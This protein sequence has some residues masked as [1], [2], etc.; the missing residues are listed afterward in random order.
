[1]IGQ[2]IAPELAMVPVRTLLQWLGTDDRPVADEPVSEAAVEPVDRPVDTVVSE[3]EACSTAAPVAEPE[4]GWALS[5]NWT[6]PQRRGELRKPNFSVSADLADSTASPDNWEFGTGRPLPEP[7]RVAGD[8]AI[9]DEPAVAAEAEYEP[10]PVFEPVAELEAPLEPVSPPRPAAAVAASLGLPPPLV[11]PVGPTGF[12]A[13][14]VDA[15]LVPVGRSLF[16]ERRLPNG[17]DEAVLSEY[18]AESRPAP[19]RVKPGPTARPAR[20]PAPRVELP[21]RSVGRR[22]PLLA[23]PALLG[24]CVIVY[25]VERPAAPLPV[26]MGMIRGAP[27]TV[28]S[29]VAGVLE[30]RLAAPGAKLM[31][32][33]G[34][35]SVLPEAD[36]AQA[37]LVAQQFDAARKHA[38]E[39]R[40][41]VDNFSRAAKLARTPATRLAVANLLEQA[42]ADNVAAMDELDRLE[43][44]ALA[45]TQRPAPMVVTAERPAIVGQFLIGDGREVG[46]GAAVVEIADCG[47]LDVVLDAKQAAKIGFKG[48]QAVRIG[49][50]GNTAGVALHLPP[51]LPGAGQITL[52]LDPAQLQAAGGDACPIGQTVSV[53]AE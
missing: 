12:A 20:K 35:F 39:T 51:V 19:E 42:Q 13:P 18:R 37:D 45:T 23:I 21:R 40:V 43:R 29:P 22:W 4:Q 52:R 15:P 6:L 34:L 17:S 50:S 5:G 11:A 41:R 2:E 30:Q 14:A 32:G 53:Q 47:G 28:M 44:A 48:G 25:W 31:A 9:H 1:M 36:H 49:L 27:I 26:M 7:A 46:F 38:D 16:V 10:E 24:I 3:P 33:A 8:E